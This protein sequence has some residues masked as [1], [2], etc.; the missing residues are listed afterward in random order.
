MTRIRVSVYRRKE[1][2]Q[3]PWW[4]G[5]SL[6][7]GKRVRK[8][9]SHRKDLAEIIARDLQRQLNLGNYEPDTMR[10]GE[11]LA[12]VLAEV[13][14]NRSRRTF[15]S[16]Q[17]TAR[18]FTE[19]FGKLRLANVTPG[20]VQQFL[21]SLG[22][23]APATKARQLRSLSAMFGS[24][25][26]WGYI[27]S[28][29]CKAI[30]APRVPKNPP[31]ILS[32][33]E[34]RGLLEAAKGTLLYGLVATALYAGLRR[35][36][37]VWLDWAD[38]DFAEKQIYVR[39]KPEHPLKNYQAR[40][41]PAPEPLLQ[42]LQQMLSNPLQAR[43][44]FPSPTETRWTLNTLDPHL[45]AFFKRAGTSAG[46]HRLR[47]TYASH[48]VMASVDLPSVQKLL[49]HSSITTTMIYAHVAQEHLKEQVGK[50]KY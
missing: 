2:I 23:K 8:P 50:L 45:R 7:N 46:L 10:V 36:E 9:A 43:W 37:L 35:E 25:V 18:I 49:G 13:E 32:K 33:A 15:V 1:R 5:Y 24:A 19:L 39:N 41:I 22:K 21:L 17:Q 29:P 47:H 31:Q 40:T 34:V 30:R 4:I 28:N 38:V 48:L 11:F 12:E 3:C 14:A 42:I 6:P 16:Y 44:V 26:R 27:P 20:H